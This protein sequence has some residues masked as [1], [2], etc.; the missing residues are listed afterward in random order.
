M[1]TMGIERKR[2]KR[3]SLAVQATTDRLY[4]LAHRVKAEKRFVGSARCANIEFHRRPSERTIWI[5]RGDGTLT[6][7]YPVGSILLFLDY[8][9]A[10]YRRVVCNAVGLA[11][12][13]DSER[14]DMLVWG[15]KNGISVDPK[16]SR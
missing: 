5:K 9:G 8:W 6:D 1:G 12:F 10:C 4:S 14:G 3:M 7:C 15:D 11:P 2:G 16:L 13:L